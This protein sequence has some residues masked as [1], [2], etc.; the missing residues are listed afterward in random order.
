MPY[1]VHEDEG[2]FLFL[3]DLVR[4]D[5]TALGRRNY[6]RAVELIKEEAEF[7]GME[8]HVQRFEDDKGEL[9]NLIAWKDL[10]ADKNLLLLSHYDV[11][12]ISGPWVLGGVTL[13]PFYP[14]RVDG[15]IYG[16]G[17]ADDKSAVA[18]S[19]SACGRVVRKGEAKYN[20]IV[21]VVGDEEVG[22]TGVVALAEEGLREAGVEPDAAIVIDAAPDFVGIG[23]SGVV[24]GDIVVRGRG[25][26][27]G[28]PFVALNPVH[29]AVKLADDLL[30]GFSQ[31][32]SSRL[33][34]IPSPPG[35]PVP[36]LWG[37]FSITKMEAGTQN[38]V[39]PSEAKLGFDLRFIPDESKEEVIE[40]LLAA[41]SVASC[42]LGAEVEVKVKETFNPGW[43]TEPANDFVREVL[44]SYEKHFGS[45]TIAGSLGANDG[46]VFA[47]RGIPTVSLGTIELESNA[48]GE[49]ENVR[50]SV[51]IAMRDTLV[52][53][54]SLT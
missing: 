40:K 38:N 31:V 51:V 12:P 42:K 6:R 1:D 20:P 39:I 36:K 23:A 52:D 50:E 17:A 24:H 21:A 19:L 13:D 16:R 8:T 53:L 45:R 7:I 22:G 34:M 35:S 2:M 41:V 26:H 25:G 11:V 44:D 15:K 10:G 32:H 54:M 47:R 29:L 5:T 37:R 43:M 3:M 18:L 49:L 33:S 28:R 9:L 30:T 14:I 4:I 46:F 48:H 27:A